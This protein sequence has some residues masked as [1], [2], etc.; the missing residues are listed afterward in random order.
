M[1][2]KTI[3]ALVA[4]QGEQLVQLGRNFDRHCEQQNGTINRLAGAVEKQADQNREDFAALHN[5]IDGRLP[6]WAAGALMVSGTIIGAA[7]A[8]IGFLLRG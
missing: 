6:A 7:L 1:T 3:E 4:T 5:K 8:A 2:A